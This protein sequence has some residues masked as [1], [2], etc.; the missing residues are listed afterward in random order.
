MNPGDP[1]FVR[2]CECLTKGALGFIGDG[3]LM[4]VLELSDIA[5]F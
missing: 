5:L 2:G 4:L 3:M 1:E